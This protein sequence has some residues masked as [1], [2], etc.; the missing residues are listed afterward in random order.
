MRTRFKRSG[1]GSKAGFGEPGN[2]HA[3]TFKNGFIYGLNKYPLSWGNDTAVSGL[4][5]FGPTEC[6]VKEPRE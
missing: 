4:T 5:S 3:Y 2:R 6:P 1:Y